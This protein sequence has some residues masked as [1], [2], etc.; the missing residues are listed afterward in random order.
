MPGRIA[1][2]TSIIHVHVNIAT[3]PLRSR[4]LGKAEWLQMNRQA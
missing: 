3:Y 4:F 1:I 2:R